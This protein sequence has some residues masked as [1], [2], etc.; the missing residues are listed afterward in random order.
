MV[1]AQLSGTRDTEVA[2]VCLDWASIWS[3][4]EKPVCMGGAIPRKSE[5][6]Y[7]GLDSLWWFWMTFLSTITYT[8][9]CSI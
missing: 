8:C 6:H 9:T 7:G 1:G 3:C 4:A 2:P 5:L